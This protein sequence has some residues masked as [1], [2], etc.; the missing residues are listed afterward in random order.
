M[1]NESQP[2]DEFSSSDGKTSIPSHTVKLFQVNNIQIPS[3][4]VE[5]LHQFE[6]DQ[7]FLKDDC[8]NQ[9]NSAPFS[10]TEDEEGWMSLTK[11]QNQNITLTFLEQAKTQMGTDLDENQTKSLCKLLL[12]YQNVFGKKEGLTP[13]ISHKIENSAV[14]FSKPRRQSQAEAENANKL[15]KEM[16]KDGII[17]PSS[18][19]YNSPVIFVTKKDGSI[20]FCID[21][22]KLNKHTKTSKYPLTNPALCF[23]KLH[24]AYYFSKLDLQ[25][26]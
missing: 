18:S 20:R 7:S 6:R 23:D 25:A 19:P 8:A 3:R 26:A 12:K 21:Y 17:R 2:E 13:L 1:E 11:P 16:L 24:N 10:V 9:T 5:I 22:R 15:T 14:V 4:T